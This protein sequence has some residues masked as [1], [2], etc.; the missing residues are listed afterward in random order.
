VTT[1]DVTKDNP[2][3]IAIIDPAEN[4]HPERSEIKV[5]YSIL[6]R[7][8][9]PIRRVR[10]MMDGRVVA[11][12]KNLTVPANGK[13]NGELR[14]ALQGEA[15]LL[16]LFAE[17]D[18]GSSDPTSV[19]LRRGP[20]SDLPKPD[21]YVLAVGIN[22]FH[23]ASLNLKY[24]AADAND[25]AARLRRQEGGLYRRVQIRALVNQEATQQAILD[26][27]E[28]LEREMT[29]RDV[30]AV[31]VST[32]GSNDAR[33]DFYLVATDTEVSD[34][35]SKR[36][37]GV[38]YAD[39]RQTLIT[40]AERGKTLVFLDACHS[41]SITPG[42]KDAPADLDK[43][44]ADLAAAEN[45]VIVFSSS[46]GT[47]LSQERDEL[48]HGAFTAALLEAFDGRGKT[49]DPPWL[50]VSDFDIWLRDRVK[51]LTNGAQ[52]PVTTVPNERFTNPRV[53]RVVG[54]Q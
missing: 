47:Q 50:Y 35:I 34:D 53:F 12:A 45:G 5:A 23:D 49:A 28:W 46:T 10:L 48:K 3:R 42:S 14:V 9:T 44:A 27:L 54:A 15:P 7:P 31:F 13:L 21:L 38:R 30:A 52:T 6:D 33:G 19:H 1:K 37:T 18:R 24:A 51:V 41:G 8:A 32:H 25:F 40:L 11:E 26:G 17:S 43:V 39:L 29:Q 4:T 22:Q 16:T 36:R 2:P 20:Q